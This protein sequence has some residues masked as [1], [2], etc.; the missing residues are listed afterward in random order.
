MAN[1]RLRTAIAGAGYTIQSLADAVEVDPK[2]VQRWV[3]Q[4]RMPH[5]STRAAVVAVLGGDE[6]YYWPALLDS[7]AALSASRSELVQLWPSRDRVPSD[8]WRSLIDG[9]RAHLDLLAYSGGHLVEVYRLVDHI[10]EHAPAGLRVRLLLGDDTSEPVRAR[11]RDEGLPSLPARAASTREYL[12]DVLAL[13]SVELRVHQTPLY[14]SLYRFDDDL[15]VN[16]HTHGLPAKDNPV[17]H[18]RA[19]EGGALWR[20]Y[21]AAFER[22]WA[23]GYPP[24]LDA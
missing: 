18:Y 5:P 2:S 14:A 3:T 17:H 8:V 1:E 20:Y 9:T 11:G 22:V 16:H 4:D 19:V 15:L 12:A 13:E 7:P 6:V 21:V 10:A 24:T 23:T